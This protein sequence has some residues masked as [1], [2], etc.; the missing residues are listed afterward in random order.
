MNFDLKWNDKKL[1]GE[2]KSVCKKA[3]ID[4]AKDV[5]IDA[6]MNAPVDKGD[7]VFSI[8]VKSW[9][10]A[11]AVGAYVSAGGKDRGHIARFVELGTPGTTFKST[12]GYWGHESG[13]SMS[14]TPI[15]AKPYLRPALKK[16][17]KSIVLKFRG[18]L[19]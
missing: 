15:K 8:E 3:C 5:A 12:K 14:R 10:K 9:E 17:K 13:R 1:F 4:G 7:L 18:K 2:V 19:K 6:K 16:K 11:D